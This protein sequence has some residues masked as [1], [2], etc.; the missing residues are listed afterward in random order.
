VK[1]LLA[2]LLALLAFATPVR[3]AAPPAKGGMAKGGPLKGVIVGGRLLTCALEKG[4]GN[5]HIHALGK[6]TPARSVV[7]DVSNLPPLRWQVGHGAFW[8]TQEWASLGIVH[9]ET[10]LLRYDLDPLLK[11]TP[12][13]WTNAFS[14]DTPASRTRMRG[15][16]P[17]NYPHRTYHDYLPAGSLTVRQFVLTDVPGRRR[18]PAPAEEVVGCR[19]APPK[20][21]PKP[22]LFTIYHY[23][24][25]WD[26][27]NKVWDLRRWSREGSI[28]VGFR[29][30]F[31]ALGRGDDF[32]FLTRSGKLFRAPKPAKGKD[33]AIEAVWG[34]PGRPITAVLGDAGSGRTFLFV[35]PAAGKGKPAFFELAPKPK[36]GEY[37]PAAVPPPRSAG[38][39]RALLHLARVLVALKKV[40]A[41]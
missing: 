22:W 14:S 13:P 40:K 30:P 16:T 26:V 15:L 5:A 23:E 21:A 38:P 7:C 27:K 19:E 32:Y 31:W 39:D 25:R 6:D 20:P 2:T 17:E 4:V 12:T 34:A 18:A 35:P 36:L 37:D 33:R 24:G 3:A 8:L 41:E 29:E 1:H 11:G 9:R 10:H 28:Q